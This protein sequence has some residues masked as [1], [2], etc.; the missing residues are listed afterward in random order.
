MIPWQQL[1]ELDKLQ[2]RSR[3]S[4]AAD[5]YRRRSRSTCP[6][7]SAPWCAIG[8]ASLE[9]ALRRLQGEVAAELHFQPF[10]LHPDMGAED[11]EHLAKKYG[12]SAE[13]V[14][15]NQQSIAERGRFCLRPHGAAQLHLNTFDAHRPLHWAGEVGEATA[16]QA[17]AALA[18]T[19][20]GENGARVEV[21]CAAAQA[22]LD[23]TRR[24]R[25]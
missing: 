16:P 19:S 24:R 20:P 13:Q 4:G 5:G 25:G 11:I 9:I 3:R 17:C 22:G 10:E 8:L 23:A 18:P 15:R 1:A 12:M 6:T 21:L 7:W 2:P 14:E